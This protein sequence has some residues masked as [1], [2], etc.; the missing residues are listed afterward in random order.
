MAKLR[1]AKVLL[2]T[3]EENIVMVVS[4]CGFE[5]ETVIL[6]EQLEEQTLMKE[7][8]VVVTSFAIGI[9]SEPLPAGSPLAGVVNVEK[10]WRIAPA[11]VHQLLGLCTRSMPISRSPTTQECFKQAH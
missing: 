9:A 10:V 3:A 1:G 6:T 8:L 5:D 2:R 11:R 4:N 7:E